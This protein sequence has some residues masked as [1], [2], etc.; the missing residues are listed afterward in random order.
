MLGLLKSCPGIGEIGAVKIAAAVVDPRRFTSKG[1]FHAYCGLVKYEKMSGGQSY[2]TVRANYNRTLK[3]VF[4]VAAMACIQASDNNFLKQDYEY[5]RTEKRLADHN[6][7]HAIARKAATI[8]LGVMKSG[9]K[10]DIDKRRKDQA[11][12]KKKK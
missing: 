12:K 5:L 7:R 3:N 8:A 1:K 9:K 11:E 4:D 2:G 6:A 10:F